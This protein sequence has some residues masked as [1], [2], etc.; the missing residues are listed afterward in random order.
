MR[1]IWMCVSLLLLQSL[2]VGNLIYAQPTVQ[3]LLDPDIRT[4]SVGLEPQEI[5]VQAQ[6]DGEGWH[7][8]WK[9]QGFGEFQHVGTGGIYSAPEQIEEASATAIITVTATDDTGNTAT[10]TV[11]LTLI[12]SAPSPTPLPESTVPP[13]PTIPPTPVPLP[14]RTPPPTP[15]P[16][17]TP[18][19]MISPTATPELEK[20]EQHLQN[21]DA[22]L[23][24][25]SLTTPKNANA[26]DEYK[27]VLERDPANSDAREG[28]Y[29]ILDRYELWAEEEYKKGNYRRTQS[30]YERY[31]FVADYMLNTLGDEEIRQKIQVVK[32]RLSR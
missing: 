17:P 29:A 10:D 23:A 9:F 18:T 20:I 5:W 31:L 14:T 19:L 22:Y 28:M 7:F 32:N 27:A 16:E 2:L 15:T 26:F 1:L 24:R 8:T 13:T 3:I 12:P 25:K 6:L 21:A 4:L 11:V 30:L